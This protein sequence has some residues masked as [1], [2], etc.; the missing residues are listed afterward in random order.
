M[1]AMFIASCLF[2][3]SFCDVTIEVVWGSSSCLLGIYSSG[4]CEGLR[5]NSFWGGSMVLQLEIKVLMAGKPSAT[6]LP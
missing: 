5:L 1:C 4:W 2:C 3:R 6:L